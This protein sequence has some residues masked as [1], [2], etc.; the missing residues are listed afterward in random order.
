MDEEVYVYSPDLSVLK[1]GCYTLTLTGKEADVVRAALAQY[2]DRMEQR[3]ALNP[4]PDWFT[5]ERLCDSVVEKLN[6][7]EGR[8]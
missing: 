7:A 5:Q 8:G 6:K 4:D 2:A 1:A 3:G